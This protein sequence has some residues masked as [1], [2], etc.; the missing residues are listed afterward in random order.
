M[1]FSTV[2]P[3]T[4]FLEAVRAFGITISSISSGALMQGQLP[5][6]YRGR[7]VGIIRWVSVIAIPLSAL[8]GGWLA[9]RLGVATLFAVGGFWI[10]GISAIAWLNRHLRK[11]R[12]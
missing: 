2:I 3:L 8:L 12:L 9:D 4:A 5:Q 11:A 7:G 1:A 10:L 6:E